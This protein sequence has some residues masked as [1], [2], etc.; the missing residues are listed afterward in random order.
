MDRADLYLRYLC[1]L[2]GRE[3]YDTADWRAAERH[4][5]LEYE[6]GVI[7]RAG[8][9]AA[10]VMLA[11]FMGFC[12]RENIAY[13]FGRGSVG[14]SYAGFLAGIHEVDSIQWGLD[15]ERFLNPERVSYP[16]V[17]IDVGQRQRERVLQYI[18]DTY[19]TGDQVVLQVGAF[20]RAGGRAVVDAMAA[21]YSQTDQFAYAT[22]TNLKKCF[23]SGNLSGG[24][25][26]PRE[27]AWWLEN[28]HGKKEEFREMAE[29]A[30]WLDTMLLLDGMF[31]NLSRH[32]AGVVILRREDLPFLPR[33]DVRNSDGSHQTV[34]G[35]DMYALDDLGY[36]KW[37][38]LGLRTLDVVA[39]AHRFT[40]GTGHTRDLLKL[41]N[42][43][44]DVDDEGVYRVLQEADTTGIFQM[45]TPGFKRALRDFQPTCFEHIV[46]L[47]ALYRPGALDYKREEDGKNMV[48]V[49][50]ARRHGREPVTYPEAAAEKLRPILDSTHGI[51][52]YQEQ[53][54]RIVREI[55]GFT[56]GQA[57]S[58]RKAIGKKR[59]EEMAK[60]V[61]LWEQG[62]Q[63]L[64]KTVRD[65]LWENLEAAA[66]YSWNRSH[67]VEY[68][69]ETWLTC[70]FKSEAP[71][72]LYAAEI[73][74]LQK[75]KDRQAEVVAEARQHATFRPP[76]INVAEDRF[77]V[78]SA[79]EIVF[80]LN[81]IKGIGEAVRNEVLMQRLLNGPYASFEEFCTRLPGVGT[82][83]KRSL[84]ACGAFDGLGEDRLRLLATIPKGDPAWDTRLTCGC[85]SRRKSPMEPGTP[86]RCN[87]HREQV[88]VLGATPI[89]QKRWT[90]LEHVND[91]AKRVAEGKPSKPLPPFDEWDIP[92]DTVLA[93]GEMEAMGYYISNVPL[94]DV[95][96]ALRRMPAGVIGGEVHS[97]K[98]HT[99]RNDNEM[100][101]L[102]LTTP[103]LTRQ[104]V[105]IFASNW[106]TLQ[107][108][109]VEK[110]A[111]L[112]FQG[113][114]DGD[115]F[116]ADN[117][118]PPARY[119]HFH[120]VRLERNGDKEYRS[121][122]GD[123]TEATIRQLEEQGYK[124]RC[125]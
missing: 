52:L 87:M 29:Q 13:G 8:F 4:E 32:A 102:S 83:K 121:F 15:F 80:G 9:S 78:A 61:P 17:D 81:G 106:S 96:N 31:T 74:S 35:Y 91:S 123:L 101:T 50:I 68:G 48:E 75:D 49:F 40:G 45:D 67:A 3:R 10:F 34:T 7:E 56:G 22:A 86:I 107:H 47:V 125:L 59:P 55:A 27:L 23:P 73:N 60:L 19:Q 14:G 84:V 6:L 26:V 98:V 116:L 65:A 109:G 113:R 44:R 92:T 104:R 54:M 16:D 28:G 58:L 38:I 46:Q 63:W 112:L 66:R 93:Q 2:G 43:H 103:A 100:A 110:G 108:R 70:W 57:D 95:T 94:A 117:A 21:A 64:P 36:L 119:A 5:R 11:D 122:S 77:I 39:D 37:D 97:I 90:V 30:G 85:N 42:E 72:A 71:A 69:A 82:D 88:Y 51:I 120:K 114:Q 99:D 20:R 12:R 79:D 18:V 41:W 89:E 53:Q 115:S 111:K 105:R 33:V 76:D 62:T 118:W 25:K 1:E 24:V 124:V